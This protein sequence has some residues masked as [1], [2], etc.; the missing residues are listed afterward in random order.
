MPTSV[1]FN[2]HHETQWTSCKVIIPG[3]DFANDSFR[4]IWISRLLPISMLPVI[5]CSIKRGWASSTVIR[6][7]TSC[8][9]KNLLNLIPEMPLPLSQA[10][11][12]V[13]LKQF[14]ENDTTNIAYKVQ[15]VI[16]TDVFIA[17]SGPIGYVPYSSLIG[18]WTKLVVPCVQ[19]H[20]RAHYP[21]QE[22]FD[23]HCYG[24]NRFSGQPYPRRQPQERDKVLLPIR[25]ASLTIFDTDLGTRKT[26]THSV[27]PRPS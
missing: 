9:W 18:C 24:R 20:L 1:K 27:S 6:T 22:A 5:T 21:W 25:F 4:S 14:R 10:D 23:G 11:A 7:S 3:L 17:G 8:A 15:R 16:L 13:L 26:S 2:I 19:M 12:D